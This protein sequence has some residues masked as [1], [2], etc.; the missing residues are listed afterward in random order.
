M[1][2]K[3]VGKTQPEIGCG[4]VLSKWLGR[5]IFA[6]RIDEIFAAVRQKVFLPVVAVGVGAVHL[7]RVDVHPVLAVLREGDVQ[8][9]E[10]VADTMRDVLAQLLLLHAVLVQRCHEIRQRS[11]HSKCD[12]LQQKMI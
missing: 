8:R 3:W 6:W 2:L 1:Y 10:V 5:D 7:P 4:N 9:D 12:F 11:S